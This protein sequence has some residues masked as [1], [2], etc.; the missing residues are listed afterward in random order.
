MT[1]GADILVRAL[2]A[3]NA[4]LIFGVPGESYL[5]VLD[6]L[7]DQPNLRFITTRHEGGAAF[8]ADAYGKLTGRPGICFVTRGPGA[9]NASIG[10]HT[11]Q[12]DS[13]PLVMFVGQIARGMAEREAFQEVDYRRYFGHMAKWVAQIDDPARIPEFINRAFHTA[14]SGRP[15]PVVLALPED[16]LS[17]DAAEAEAT[18]PAR[19]I[20]PAPRAQDM[21]EFAD[22]LARAERPLV[23]AGGGGW[24]A[25]TAR[26]LAAWVER[27]GLPVALEFRCQDYLDNR[28]PNYVGDAG[29]GM[30]TYLAEMIK[31]SDCLILVG[32]RMGEMPTSGYTLLGIPHTGKTLVHVHPDAQELNRV[33]YT[34]LPM[35]AAAEAFL[36]SALKAPTS[37]RKTKWDVWR[38]AGRRGYEASFKVPPAP[39]AVDLAEI[40]QDL[41]KQLPDD[42][43]VT[44]GA[45]NYTVWVHKLWTYKHY[46]TQLA[47]VSGAMGYGVPAAVAAA[48]VHPD[49]AVVCFAGD[50]CFLMTGQELATAV[51]HRLKILFL[52]VNNGLL[53]T[54]RMH[55]EREFPGR[56]SATDLTN[57]DFAAYARSFGAWGGVVERSED[58]GAVLAQARAVDGPALIEIRVDPEALTLRRTLTEIRNG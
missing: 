40:M 5:S 2:A 7:V 27:E 24:S 3:Q 9:T 34:T 52:V 56:V 1:R 36:S 11:A 50:G 25:E 58:F 17:A 12:Q 48:L 55:Q 10:I 20:M 14:Q 43:I 30:A 54:I 35:H 6:A 57:P 22:V 49:R 16:V 39:G 19:R 51:R 46:R 41:Q 29:I 13:T 45:G 38:Q 18:D 44:N 4:D 26:M 31:A 32:A 33:Y 15:G 42:T 8:M 37:D 47:P 21:A 23:I 28:H 53:G